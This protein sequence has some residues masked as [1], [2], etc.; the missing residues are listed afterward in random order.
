MKLTVPALILLLST[1]FSIGAQTGGMFQQDVSW[2]P[3]GKQLAF[4]GLHDFDNVNHKFKADIY[5]IGADG[6]GQRQ[7]TGDDR[8]EFYTA[9]A[10]DRIAFGVETPGIKESQ[11]YT[12]KP[13]G[14][15]A[16]QITKSTGKNATPAFSRDGKRIAFVSTRDAEKYQ[17]Y[18][19]NT[20]GT[21]VKRLTAD[22]KVGFFNP[23]FSPN[24]KQIVYY[25]EKDDQ[26]DQ[27]WVMN[28]DGSRPLLLTANIGHN[29]FPG[30]SGDGKHIIFS[31]SKRDAAAGGTYI[32]GSFLYVMNTDGSGLAKIGNINSFF[33]RYSPNGKKIA[34]ISGKFPETAIYIANADGSGAVKITK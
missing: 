25:A 8:N 4:C 29:I 16:R 2:S 18:V 3:D 6:S 1:V 5:V 31:S 24:G 15:D 21:D 32:E 10:K 23:Q 13:D 11:I 27:I 20:D 7:I 30:W 26:K 9:W 34:Y 12:A 14:T 22:P 33:A 19:M 28:A 17:I